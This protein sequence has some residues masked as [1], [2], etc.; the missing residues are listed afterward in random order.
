MAKRKRNGVHG[1]AVKKPAVMATGIP[2]PPHDAATPPATTTTSTTP[3]NAYAVI[4]PEEIDV[5][6]ETLQTLAE[7]P[8][9]I[10]SKACKE[11]RTAVYAFRQAS[12]TGLIA[13]GE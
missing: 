3:T 9:L 5:T 11:L 8:A 13:A 4:S 2:S 1:N 6:V 10:K 7:H 12:T